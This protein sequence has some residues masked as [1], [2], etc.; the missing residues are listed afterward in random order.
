MV[1]TTPIRSAIMQYASS[2][3]AQEAGLPVEDADF[4]DD[5][6]RWLLSAELPV[7]DG[8]AKRRDYR[9][10]GTGTI[11]KGRKLPSVTG[12]LS[13]LGL[14]KEAIARWAARE[15]ASACAEYLMEGAA[16]GDA[17]QRARFEPFRKRDDAAD[18][19]T[20]A[21][22]M[23]DAFLKG[24][25]IEDDPFLPS[26][27]MRAA[28]GALDRFRAWW[29]LGEYE[30][31]HTELALVDQRMGYGGTID[32]V[33]RRVRDGA[34]VVGDLKTGKGVY[35]EQLVQLGGYSLLLHN[36]AGLAVREGLLIH[37][38]LEKLGDDGQWIM[39]DPP[40]RIVPIK[41]EV[42]ALG[43]ST[44]AA[45]FWIWHARKQLTLEGGGDGR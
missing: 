17:I 40:R 27:V 36:V 37:I 11:P 7:V 6:D 19:G 41:G 1:S 9:S 26:T 20:L 8:E 25:E 24:K 13:L 3:R 32:S 10:D 23:I 16:P 4:L 44:F 15:A 42:L 12:I 29:E 18:A 5:L 35:D 43:A 22:A 31:L 2:L 21:H 38:P 14:S 34:L 30:V 39:P 28:R 33:L 45:L